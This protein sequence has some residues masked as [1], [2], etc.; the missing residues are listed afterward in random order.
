MYCIIFGCDLLSPRW[1]ILFFSKI[2]YLIA[3]LDIH[4]HGSD[5]P[6]RLQGASRTSGGISRGRAQGNVFNFADAMDVRPYHRMAPRGRVY[7][8]T[9]PLNPTSLN[10][11]LMNPMA[12]VKVTTSQTIAP[13][14]QQVTRKFSPV[15]SKYSLDNML[16]YCFHLCGREQPTYL[17]S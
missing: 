11:D 7:V 3:I 5:S 4:M 9:S 16:K 2:N 14:L 12:S 1:A 17:C 10:P 8:Y 13:I 6:E 15:C